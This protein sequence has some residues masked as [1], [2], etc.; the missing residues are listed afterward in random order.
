MGAAR[1]QVGLPSGWNAQL[2]FAVSPAP[3]T[4]TTDVSGAN[5]FKSRRVNG[6]A[7]TVTIVALPVTL[8]RTISTLA[9][10]LL[11]LT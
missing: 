3:S 5:H 4:T 2:T 11:F 8:E 9:T 7:K 6:L 1:L 10:M